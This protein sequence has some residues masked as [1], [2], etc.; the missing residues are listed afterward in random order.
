[1]RLKLLRPADRKVDGL[2]V[3]AVLALA[4]VFGVA[5]VGRIPRGVLPQGI[6]TF[7]RLTGYPCLTCGGTRA[8]IALGNLDLPGAF[9]WNP[10]VAA[11][12]LLAAPFGL[13]GTAAWWFSWPRPGLEIPSRQGKWLLG[14]LLVGL[15]AANW[16]YLII[17]KV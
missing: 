12:L 8:A 17:A 7:H 1:M 4:L 13:W 9:R 11:V 6:C 14:I 3:F 16:A 15:L 5:V 10:L 2:L